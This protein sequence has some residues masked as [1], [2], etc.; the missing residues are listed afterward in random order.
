M[1]P[2]SVQNSIKSVKLVLDSNSTST[3]F[4]SYP[5]F[6]TTL[7]ITPLIFYIYYYEKYIFEPYWNGE[8]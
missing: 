1:R 2:L 5:N 4:Y 7:L 6:H 3:I 8:N